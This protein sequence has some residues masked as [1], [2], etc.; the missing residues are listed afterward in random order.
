MCHGQSVR[1]DLFL[2]HDSL[3]AVV[4]DQALHRA[5]SPQESH[6]SSLPSRI[7]VAVDE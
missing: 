1:S 3:S 5:V 4:I 6:Q 7:A 2:D